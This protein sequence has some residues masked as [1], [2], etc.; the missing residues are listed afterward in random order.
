MWE[1]G[2]PAVKRY[3]ERIRKVESFKLATSMSDGMDRFLEFIKNPVLLTMLATAAVVGAGYYL[4]KHGMFGGIISGIG[5]GGKD[6]GC[7]VSE[8]ESQPL[9]ISAPVRPRAP[10]VSARPPPK[11]GPL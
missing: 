10:S 11:C 6:C 7:N 5:G 4:Y 3:F 8:F 2:R 9:A 1:R